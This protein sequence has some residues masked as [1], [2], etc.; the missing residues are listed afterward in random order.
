MTSLTSLRVRGVLSAV[1]L[2]AATIGLPLALAD[3]VGDPLHSW[4]SLS[5]GQ[6]SDTNVIAIL[7]AVFWIGWL[8]FAVPA[9]LEVVLA[10]RARITH[11]P[12]REIHLP[13]LGSQQDLARSLISAIL[14]LLGA[15]NTVGA[16]APAHVHAVQI[17]RVT[18]TAWTTLTASP[19][20]HHAHRPSAAGQD[21]RERSYV[22]P[23][24]G[25]MRSY[26]AL[27]EHYF[28][29]G[30]RWREIWHL[31]QGRTHRDGTVMDTPRQLHSG[32]TILIP[33]ADVV[34][35]SHHED[36]RSP[37]TVTVGEGDTLSSIAERHSLDDWQQLW[38]I[39]ADRTEP[40]G[41]R[42]TDPGLIYPGW[43]LTVP[44]SQATDGRPTPPPTAGTALP[45]DHPTRPSDSD[46][47]LATVR[48][49][50]PDPTPT[51][52]T[53]PTPP[54]SG[55]PSRSAASN[56]GG[57][58][59][60]HDQHHDPGHRLPV[61]PL[62]IGL[63]A[64]AAVAALDRARRIAQRRRRIGHRPLPPPEPLRRVEA[65]LRHAARAA[66]PAVAAVELATALTATSPATVEIKAVTAHD[67]G[68]VDL[69]L[70]PPGPDLPPPPPPFVA[71]PGGWR[72]PAA[73]TGFSFAVDSVDEPV[74]TLTPVGC[75]G[76]GEVLVPLA[77]GAPV[78]I[79]GD[80]DAVSRYLTVLGEALLAAPWSGRVFLTVPAAMRDQLAATEHVTVVDGP[81]TLPSAIPL[82]ASG[83]EEPGWCTTP[84]H[85]YLGWPATDPIDDL[86]R[87]AADPATSVYAILTGAHAATTVW[88]LDGDQLT[89]PGLDRPLTVTLPDPDK[90]TA[91]DLIAHTSTAHEVPVGDPG[92]PDH[93]LDAPPHRA[94][95]SRQLNL[96]GPVELVGVEPPKR[97]QIL[98]LLT[99]LA[100]HRRGADHDTLDT[101]LWKKPVGGKTLRNRMHEARQ[102]V[103]G[104]IT[105][106][107]IW[108]LT[109]EVTTDW[110]RFTALAAGTPAEQREALQLIR[111]RPFQGLDYADWLHLEG[112]HSEVEAAI[113]D[114]AITVTERELDNGDPDAAYL[115]ARAG[116]DASRYEERLHRLAII[117]AEAAGHTSIVET[118]KAEMRTAIEDDI[119]PDSE[120][121]AE[122]RDLYERMR[123]GR[124]GIGGQV[125]SADR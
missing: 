8:S 77:H 47:P 58:T 70:Q 33:P 112:I 100:L 98:N 28:G 87:V 90:P 25:G 63:A 108:R 110:Q 76:D 82:A 84:V 2:C 41:R 97:S 30:T 119:E 24:I 22:I 113:V 65:D 56:G 109:D 49:P 1:L 104:A 10:V 95:T 86:V 80:P 36:D 73:D 117:T 72:L 55:H 62:G 106:G 42:F 19:A 39:N 111:G 6:L 81:P 121:Q 115:A 43:T 74:P 27:A 32:W 46:T 88:T 107:P 54:A 11:R 102:L 34:D 45:H 29:D 125:T 120:L 116:L 17:T 48:T 57:A 18:D 71:I 9:V 23:D 122:T 69:H 60:Q 5:S 105:D 20:H 26:W 38:K 4:P 44:S 21:H 103:G 64:A 83:A 14:L 40:D 114:L 85:L 92:L 123:R 94:A 101:V 66:H 99:Y 68:A 50:R 7:A 53:E 52:V 31:N 12:V 51:G 75:S 61:V 91:A 96:L 16:A 93:L 78:S 79:A 15:Q 59:N 13:L 89:I 118:L 67:D 3:T 37:T 124:T 35:P